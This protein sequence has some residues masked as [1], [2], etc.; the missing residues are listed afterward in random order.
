[1]YLFRQRESFPPKNVKTSRTIAIK[2]H[3]QLL[4]VG[5]KSP[6]RCYEGNEE[7]DTT[8]IESSALEVDLVT[9]CKARLGNGANRRY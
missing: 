3:P 1:M 8:L 5:M 2:A 4:C 7:G 9:N 6:L